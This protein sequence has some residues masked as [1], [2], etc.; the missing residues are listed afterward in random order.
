MVTCKSKIKRRNS[1]WYIFDLS[2]EYMCRSAISIHCK[3]F[4]GISLGMRFN[5][6]KSWSSDTVVSK[7]L[8]LISVSVLQKLGRGLDLGIQR[9]GLDNNTGCAQ[10]N[11]TNLPIL[12]MKCQNHIL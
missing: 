5:W 10:I 11:M 4:T 7:I 3:H 8:I 2:F 9:T 6:L 12:S 1:F